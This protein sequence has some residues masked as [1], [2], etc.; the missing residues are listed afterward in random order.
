MIKDLN[1][2]SVRLV[3]VSVTFTNQAGEQSV[4]QGSLPFQPQT[5]DLLTLVT[6]Y[7][8]DLFGAVPAEV[9][10]SVRLPGGDG[11]VVLTSDGQV[12]TVLEHTKDTQK[13]LEIDMVSKVLSSSS[14]QIATTTVKNLV[15]PVRCSVSGSPS[16]NKMFPFSYSSDQNNLLESLLNDCLAE[17]DMEMSGPMELVCHIH[18]ESI[19]ITNDAQVRELLSV[20]SSDN[21]LQLEVRRPVPKAKV[22]YVQVT[23]QMGQDRNATFRFKYLQNQ[24]SLVDA[25]KGDC[26][27]ELEVQNV[28]AAYELNCQLD[29]VLIPVTSDSQL[30]EILSGV[31]SGGLQVEL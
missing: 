8:C 21:I 1:P 20:A 5:E 29:G 30:R 11:S 6:K 13:P 22:F 10:L 25:L 17:L 9:Q 7:C 16:T 31:S 2:Q 3:D 14:E 12:R 19:Q 18:G 23:C 27:A 28:D 15:A 24:D 26:L 4:K